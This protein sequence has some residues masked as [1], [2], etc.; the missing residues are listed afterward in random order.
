MGPTG[1]TSRTPAGAAADWEANGEPLDGSGPDL[2]CVT[3]DRLETSSVNV[4]GSAAAKPLSLECRALREVTGVP[5][6]VAP[7]RHTAR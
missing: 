2:W 7:W 4:A 3:E 1:W 5:I 6:D